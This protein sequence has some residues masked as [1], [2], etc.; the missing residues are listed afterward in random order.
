MIVTNIEEVRKISVDV[1]GSKEE[2]DALFFLLDSELRASDLPGVGLSGV[3]IGILERIA[4]VRTN[5]VSLNLYN[6]KIIDGSGSK[7]AEEGCLSLPNQFMPV[8][9]KTAIAIQNGD[10]QIIKLSGYAARVAQHEMD[11]W[12]GILILDRRV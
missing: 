9:R 1:V 8:E 7:I 6:A 4:I 2:L 11:H 3:Q 5:K 12:E 10:G